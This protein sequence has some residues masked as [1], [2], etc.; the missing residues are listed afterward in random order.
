MYIIEIDPAKLSTSFEDW[1]EKD[2]LKLN[3]WDL[4]QVEIK[5]YSAELVPVMTQDGPVRYPADVGPAAEMTLD[6]NDA[7]AKWNAGEAAR[8]DPK[9][10]EHGDYVDFTLAEDEELNDESLNGLKTALEDLKIVDVV[11]KPQG[12]SEDL[13]AGEDFMKNRRSAAR[14]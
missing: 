5:D 6:Y 9:K 2:L 10:G 3:A 14:I 13:K 1:I 12:L 7:E 8:F 11:R 4:Q